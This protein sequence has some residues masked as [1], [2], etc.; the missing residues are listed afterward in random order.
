[1]AAILFAIADQLQTHTVRFISIFE[2]CRTEGVPSVLRALR[3]RSLAVKKI[4]LLF[5]S[6]E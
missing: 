1:M 2:R 4:E 3:S 6:D 5:N